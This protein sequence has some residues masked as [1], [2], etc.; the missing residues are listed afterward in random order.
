MPNSINKNYQNYTI[1]LQSSK[2]ITVFF[3]TLIFFNCE[4]GDLLY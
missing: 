2:M 4:K 1:T 3:L